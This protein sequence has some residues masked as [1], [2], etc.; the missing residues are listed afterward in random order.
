MRSIARVTGL[1]GVFAVAGLA[2]NVQ[3]Q[4]VYVTDNAT[5]SVNAGWNVKV[6]NNGS[7]AYLMDDRMGIDH[8]PRGVSFDSTGGIYVLHFSPQGPNPINVDKFSENAAGTTAFMHSQGISA[9]GGIGRPAPCIWG[10]GDGRRVD[11]DLS[12]DSIVIYGTGS[13]WNTTCGGP[14]SAPG[15]RG[16]GAYAFI[17]RHPGSGASVLDS[18]HTEAIGIQGMQ[19]GNTAS[20]PART[21]QS[22]GV[23]IDQ[24]NGDVYTAHGWD[25]G[26]AGNTTQIVERFSSALVQL[27]SFDANADDGFT[28]RTN[29]TE[30]GQ[31]AV[32][33]AGDIW[34]A[35]VTLSPA[36]GGWG[37]P[38]GRITKYSSTGTRILERLGTT[39]ITGSS[40]NNFGWG[41]GL[42]ID[43]AGVLWFGD[44]DRI[45]RMDGITGDFLSFPYGDTAGQNDTN[46]Y[47][48]GALIPNVGSIEQIAVGPLPPVG[49]SIRIQ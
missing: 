7:F 44:Q 18:S 24:S 27:S 25:G 11:V 4:K 40:R 19:W 43:E 47:G 42:D 48:E 41:G 14:N 35:D 17:K 6:F 1:I 5:T 15:G 16:P 3:A 23:H 12:D 31:V 37:G 9:G 28:T 39:I 49:S 2:L 22:G 32:N 10:T 20:Q 8:S 33:Q 45:V 13:A 21:P 34:L 26:P 29:Y 46:I 30:G 36:M 38:M